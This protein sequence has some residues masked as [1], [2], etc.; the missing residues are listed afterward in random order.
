MISLDRMKER[1]IGKTYR[2]ENETQTG[3]ITDVYRERRKTFVIVD[4]Y[5]GNLKVHVP[6]RSIEF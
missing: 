1:L 4:Y 2:N 6:L 5:G 3:I